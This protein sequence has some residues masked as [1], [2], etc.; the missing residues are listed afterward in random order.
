M[1]RKLAICLSVTAGL[2]L[3]PRGTVQAQQ[4]RSLSTVNEQIERG[5]RALDPRSLSFRIG[6]GDVLTIRVFQVPDLSGDF[7]VDYD[8]SLTMPFIQDKLRAAGKSVTQ[9]AS[10]IRLLL[11]EH[12]LVNDPQ[13]QVTIKEQHSGPVAVLGAVRAPTVFQA[14]D[15]TRLMGAL[16]RAGGLAEDAGTVA[17]IRRPARSESG[18]AAKEPETITVDLSKL[19][20]GGDLNLDVPILGGDTITVTRAGVVYVLGAVQRPGG[21]PLTHNDE[22]MTVLKAL[23]LAG[24]LKSTA[25]PERS[26]I[27]RKDGKGI[28]TAV[29]VNTARILSGQDTNAAL[30]PNDILFIPD[31]TSKKIIRRAAE[32]A[33]QITTGVVI[34][35]R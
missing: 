25:R 27:I 23:A 28:E 4:L 21:F 30:H 26:A 32:T 24:D 22:Q 2:A 7:V 19:L 12:N 15:P 31:S 35:R 17:I 14:S 5:A 9:V 34:W 10:D 13:V 3:L 6:P 33:L 8:G 16:A 20:N 11:A 1:K 29:P 18:E